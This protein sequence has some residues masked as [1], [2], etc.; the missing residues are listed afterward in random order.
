MFIV[1]R[2]ALAQRIFNGHVALS[3]SVQR[4]NGPEN[5]MWVAIW[6]S[7]EIVRFRPF[8]LQKFGTY[9]HYPIHFEERMR[10]RAGYFHMYQFGLAYGVS[11]GE[12]GHC[13][14]T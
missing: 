14:L 9:M 13:S 7:S 8:H 6:G 3:A 5:S 1:S 11:Q 2:L 10:R 12:Q 4:V